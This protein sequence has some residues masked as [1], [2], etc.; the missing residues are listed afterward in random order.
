M[1]APTNNKIT[2]ISRIRHLL[3]ELGRAV[4]RS[5]LPATRRRVIA[6]TVAT[7]LLVGAGAGT[8][9]AIASSHPSAT[10]V[11]NICHSQVEEK[12][13]WPLDPEYRV[14]AWCDSLDPNTQARGVL[15]TKWDVDAHTAWFTNTGVKHYSDWKTS[16]AVRGS[17]VEYSAR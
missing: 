16:L 7:T 3:R 5:K 2:L 12:I 8:A 15:D 17:R 4:W 13:Q 11:Q 9:V 10:K 1:T 6:V 14:I